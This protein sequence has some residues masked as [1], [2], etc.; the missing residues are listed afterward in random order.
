VPSPPVLENKLYG[1][2]GTKQGV[3]RHAEPDW[4]MIH[5][6]LRRKDVTLSILWEECTAQHPTGGAAASTR[7][8]PKGLVNR[9][10]PREALLR[11]SPVFRP[12][13]VASMSHGEGARSGKTLG[14]C[15]NGPQQE[16]KPL[17]RATC[18]LKLFD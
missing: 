12:R 6:E 18:F 7:A 16:K 11:D 15:R 2:A 10:M 9:T 3:R 4:A 14:T 1:R 8:L 5:R 13:P 17:S